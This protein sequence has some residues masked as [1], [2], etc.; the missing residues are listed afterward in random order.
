MSHYSIAQALQ[1]SLQLANPLRHVGPDAEQ[2]Q[3]ARLEAAAPRV[4]DRDN[5]LKLV[6]LTDLTHHIE[7]WTLAAQLHQ[8][9]A[10][11]RL[12]A[13]LAT[14]R[15]EQAARAEGREAAAQLRDDMVRACPDVHAWASSSPPRARGAYRNIVHAPRPSA[16]DGPEAGAGVRGAAG[17]AGR[18]CWWQPF[19]AENESERDGRL[20]T[21]LSRAAVRAAVLEQLA[22]GHERC[23]P[24][25]HVPAFRVAYDQQAIAF[26]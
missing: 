20:S 14:A 5:R 12:I 17:G 26:R 19:W 22:R 11:M 21:G 16:P 25:F 1:F 18:R 10:D 24:A 7:H 13:E 3:H 15:V 23:A 4:G 6:L 8:W 2:D 9:E